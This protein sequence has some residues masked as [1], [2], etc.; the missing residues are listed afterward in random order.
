MA[1]SSS[2]EPGPEATPSLAAAPG[3]A[4]ALPVL[5]LKPGAQKRLVRGYP[6]AYSPAASLRGAWSGWPTAA[7]KRSGPPCSTGGR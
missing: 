5:R 1:P 3:A 6:W 4:A 7:A 2:T